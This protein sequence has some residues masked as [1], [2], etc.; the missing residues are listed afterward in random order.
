MGGTSVH[1]LRAL[2]L[3]SSARLPTWI[4]KLGQLGMR[5]NVTQN[6][7][8]KIYLHCLTRLED[9]SRLR[10]DLKLKRTIKETEIIVRNRPYT[11]DKAWKN[12][13]SAGAI[14]GLPRLEG[15]L[16]NIFYGIVLG[17]DGA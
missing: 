6:E 9:P 2:P 10:G 13:K 1:P 15:K 14:G 4:E 5:K 8:C 11:W 12:M 7:W 16:V 3:T 17:A